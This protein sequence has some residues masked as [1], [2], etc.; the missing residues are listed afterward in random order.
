MLRKESPISIQYFSIRPFSMAP[1]L[2]HSCGAVTSEHAE[3]TLVGLAISPTPLF[4]NLKKLLYL[5]YVTSGP[6]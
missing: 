4:P 3:W 5:R 1:T 2:E 6:E